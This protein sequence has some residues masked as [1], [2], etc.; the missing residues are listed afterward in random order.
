METAA[1]FLAHESKE[2]A[3]CK[4]CHWTVLHVGRSQLTRLLMTCFTPVAPSYTG[5]TQ[6]GK[7]SLISFS[8][9]VR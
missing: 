8:F 2:F 3:S 7:E 4:F 5:N 9:N 1:L 6:K